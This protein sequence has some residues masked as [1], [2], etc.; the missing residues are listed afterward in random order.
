MKGGFSVKLKLSKD[1]EIVYKALSVDAAGDAKLYLD[2]E[3]LTLMFQ[4][5]SLS[6]LRAGVNAWLRLI[7]V[8]K[9]VAGS[10]AVT[11]SNS[12][13]NAGRGTA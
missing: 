7:K 1:A 12:S 13:E 10:A 4:A 5:D 9:D 6:S 2:D 11:G 8:C 3:T